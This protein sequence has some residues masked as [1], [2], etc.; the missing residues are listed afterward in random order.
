MVVYAPLLL[1]SLTFAAIPAL[2]QID[3]QSQSGD[4]RV[5]GRSGTAPAVGPPGGPSLPPGPAL[6]RDSLG[7]RS[8]DEILKRIDKDLGKGF[9]GSEAAFGSRPLDLDR[10][11]RSPSE[12]IFK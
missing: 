7:G 5:E 4:F 12:A 6:F 11:L 2:A 8:P 9:D 1:L 10:E 3:P